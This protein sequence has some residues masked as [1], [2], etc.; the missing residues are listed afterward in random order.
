MAT[1]RLIERIL[2]WHEMGMRTEWIAK[3]TGLAIQEVELILAHKD[4]GK[5]AD[6]GQ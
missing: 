5:E 4:M 1:K 6:R 2:H 3:Q